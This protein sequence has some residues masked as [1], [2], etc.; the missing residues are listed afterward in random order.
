MY[1]AMNISITASE[2]KCHFYI[3]VVDSFLEGSIV[4]L[5]TK[6]LCFAVYSIGGALKYQWVEFM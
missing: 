1:M 6:N 3:T 2:S 5:F 4:E